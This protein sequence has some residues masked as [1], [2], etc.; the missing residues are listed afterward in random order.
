MSTRLLSWNLLFSQLMLC[1]WVATW[2]TPSLPSEGL[3]WPTCVSNN[4]HTH[5]SLPPPNSYP[6]SVQNSSKSTYK[7]LSD[8]NFYLLYCPWD[9]S[10]MRTGTFVWFI[11]CYQYITSTQSTVWYLA[12][13]LNIH[14]I[15]EYILP[16]CIKLSPI[17]PLSV[18][19]LGNN[20]ST[21]GDTKMNYMWFQLISGSV[22]FWNSYKCIKV[23]KMLIEN[24]VWCSED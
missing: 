16:H 20:N 9:V 12:V 2:V 10:S 14:W 18:H 13:T 1:P 11:Y 22:S 3:L 24:T 8:K 15:N 6:L 19:P 17:H 4:R 7:F 23:W 21:C 5:S